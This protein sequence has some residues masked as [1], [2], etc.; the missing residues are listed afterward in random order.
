[1]EE[2]VKCFPE[3][4]N[5]TVE[6]SLA[7]IRTAANL[8][9]A[10]ERYIIS[11]FSMTESRFDVLMLLYCEPQYNLDLSVLSERA[12][13]TKP[14]IKRF[15]DGLEKQGLVKRVENINDIRKQLV[16]LTPE[17]LNLMEQMLPSYYQV[18]NYFMSG[19]SGEQQVQLTE[20]LNQLK[21]YLQIINFKGNKTP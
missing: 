6:A 8:S 3:L 13:K 21:K 12:E 11:T 17:G 19:L 5:E 18:T 14:T 9:K 2:N 16:Q 15:I 4:K 1:M 10:F 7:L 20:L